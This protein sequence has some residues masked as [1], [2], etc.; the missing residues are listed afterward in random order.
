[1]AAELGAVSADHLE[2]V[3]DAAIAALAAHGTV[4]VVRSTGGLKDTIFDG[5]N[6]FTFEKA[7]LI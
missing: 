5:Q 6:G 2:Y 7:S 4:P 1:M 3:D